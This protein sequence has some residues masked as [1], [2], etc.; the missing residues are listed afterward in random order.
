MNRNEPLYTMKYVSVLLLMMLAISGL[1]AQSKNDQWL[2]QLIREKASPA[3][4]EI[5]NQPDTFRYQLI[6]TKIDRDKHNVPHLTHY[7]MNV[8]ANRYHNPASTVK[9]PTALIA[10]EQM[11]ELKSKGVNKY[12]TMLTD[13]AAPMQWKVWA[14]TSSASGLPSV[15]HYVKRIFLVSDNDSYNRLF[16]LVGNK[17]LNSRLVELG[18]TGTRI[19]RRFQA[20]PDNG[21]LYTNPIR[22]VKG[23]ELIYQQP[24]QYNDSA[25][26]FSKKLL[27]GNAHM[28]KDGK[29]VSA[30]FDFT[31]HNIFTIEDLHR[32]LQTV[33]FP[34]TVPVT[35]RFKLTEDDYELLYR[36]MGSLPFE[37]EF[38]RYD[39]ARFFDSYTKFFFFRANKNKVPPAIRVF[40]K[41]GWSYGFLTD[42]AYIIDTEKNV[43]FM[44]TGNIY[45]NKDGVI[46]DDK[47]DYDETGYPYFKEIGE[48]IYKYELERKRKQQPDLK[49]FT[50]YFS[51]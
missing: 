37:S 41:A 45:S 23:N 8:D 32:M 15:A 30:P 22:F 40:N 27:I 7:K 35:K 13:S 19:T 12:T 38:P 29:Y 44:I 4:L 18:Y 31:T 21:N 49:K 24:A 33:I 6:Y 2:E 16:E 42:A 51:R 3:L 25:F 20:V 39:T 10:L 1:Q 47:Y 48:I 17:H 43:E 11:N 26:D 36:S 50:K 5:L 46:N 9:L 14:D 34:E 28:D